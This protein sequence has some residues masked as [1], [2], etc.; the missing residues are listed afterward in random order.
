MKQLVTQPT[1]TDNVPLH[2]I[3]IRRFPYSQ[4][5]LSMIRILI[6]KLLR[7]LNLR[8]MFESNF[9]E[10]LKESGFN[11][12]RSTQLENLENVTLLSAESRSDF[13]GKLIPFVRFSKL[14]TYS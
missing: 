1:S 10:Y 9:A 5:N 2:L 13:F 8:V 7:I 11:A 14:N 12:E 6:H 3:A 4:Y